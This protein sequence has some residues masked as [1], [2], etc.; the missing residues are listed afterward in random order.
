MAVGGNAAVRFSSKRRPAVI[1][2]RPLAPKQS[3]V[4]AADSGL[5]RG[6]RA[7]LAM[8]TSPTIIGTAGGSGRDRGRPNSRAQPIQPAFSLASAWRQLT[9][10]I[11][12]GWRSA[13]PTAEERGILM[14]IN[15]SMGPL[16]SSAKVA[17][18]VRDG[19]G[20]I[21][22]GVGSWALLNATE[23]HLAANRFHCP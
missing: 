18:P 6:A 1:A 23:L 10:N 7:P 9:A 4:Q 3:R 13:R 15:A 19:I 8:T 5:L 16:A 20:C 2:R 11:L 14:L 21:A 12:R 22:G 17:D